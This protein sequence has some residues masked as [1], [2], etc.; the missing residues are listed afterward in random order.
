MHPEVIYD[1]S[2]LI[3]GKF[4]ETEKKKEKGKEKKKKKK[5]K[6]RNTRSSKFVERN[7][8]RVR[9]KRASIKLALV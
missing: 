7:L 5:K 9:T 4:W 8:A 2:G 1:C 3:R 6:N